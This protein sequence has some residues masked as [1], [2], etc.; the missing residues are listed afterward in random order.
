QA[1]V[2]GVERAEKEFPIGVGLMCIIQRILPAKEAE[3]VTDFAIEHKNTFIGLDLAD[4]EVGFEPKP[5]SPFF[6]RAKKAGLGITVHAGESNVPEAPGYIR[7]AV[8]HLGAD[9]I[10]HG[11]QAYRDENIMA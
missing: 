7:D 5:F 1:F 9:R 6:N 10:G 3:Y 4:N 2:R 8:E 11:V